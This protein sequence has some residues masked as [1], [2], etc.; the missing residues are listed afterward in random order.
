[1]E[2]LIREIRT[3]SKPAVGPAAAEFLPVKPSEPTALVGLS[4]RKA[5]LFAQEA[6][7]VFQQASGDRF[8]VG[9]LD[10]APGPFMIQKGA[11]TFPADAQIETFAC[12]GL[13]GFSLII[14]N[15]LFDAIQD[16]HISSHRSRIIWGGSFFGKHLFG[17]LFLDILTEVRLLQSSPSFSRYDSSL[18]NSTL[19]ASWADF[20]F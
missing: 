18:S 3:G 14:L 15:S 5:P 9:V 11:P 20:S 17:G 19:S 7:L 13:K 1:M 8:T 10:F 6:A 2:R 12:T 4:L 16:A